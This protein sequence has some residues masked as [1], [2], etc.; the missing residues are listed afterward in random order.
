[1]AIE[2]RD[3]RTKVSVTCD[4]LLEGRSR[5]EGRDKADI[6]REILHQ[7]ADRQLDMLNVADRLVRVEG[8]EGI[9]GERG[10]K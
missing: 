3:L 7:W 1:M 6:V 9:L 10:R 4:A 5:S 2:L 8:I